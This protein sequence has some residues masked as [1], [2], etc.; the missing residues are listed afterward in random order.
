MMQLV[1]APD[2]GGK[3]HAAAGPAELREREAAEG[4]LARDLSAKHGNAPK[5]RCP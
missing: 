4:A 5:E 2:A 3:V 1:V